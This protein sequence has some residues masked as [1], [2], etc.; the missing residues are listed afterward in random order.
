MTDAELLSGIDEMIEQAPGVG[1]C[2]YP[3]KLIRDAVADLIAERDALK[4]GNNHLR[5]VL[6]LNGVPGYGAR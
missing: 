3:F 2:A 6:T 5:N 1:L 4:D